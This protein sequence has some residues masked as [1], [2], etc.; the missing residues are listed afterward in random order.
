M[1]LP[2]VH[3][4]MLGFVDTSVEGKTVI[5][6]EG[7][8]SIKMAILLPT[9]KRKVISLTGNKKELTAKDVE[10]YFKAKK[11]MLIKNSTIKAVKVYMLT[12]RTYKQEREAIEDTIIKQHN[13]DPEDEK[14]DELFEKEIDKKAKEYVYSLRKIQKD[15]ILKA[16]LSSSKD[17][18]LSSRCIIFQDDKP[19][20]SGLYVV[21]SSYDNIPVEITPIKTK[22]GDFVGFY[23]ISTNKLISQ[24]HWLNLIDHY[25]RTI[26]TFV[27]KGIEEVIAISFHYDY[28][29]A[30]ALLNQEQLEF[31]KKLLSDI[32]NLTSNNNKIL[33]E[34][35]DKYI[36]KLEV[37]KTIIERTPAISPVISADIMIIN[38]AFPTKNSEKGNLVEVL[39]KQNELFVKLNYSK[40]SSE[41]QEKMLKLLNNKLE[42]FKT[43]QSGNVLASYLIQNDPIGKKKSYGFMEDNIQ[44][45]HAIFKPTKY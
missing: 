10:K 38:D 4:R 45:A 34:N 44:I 19:S 24:G 14:F 41:M 3:F 26:N 31:L 36:K 35:K 27:E 22:E 25:I 33:I 8:Y 32:R 9:G 13:I 42:Q 21:S 29:L 2:A 37:L 17:G 11:E 18:S 39:K 15:F 5:L 43:G 20:K 6:P 12:N 28:D 7:E 40:E 1:I 30:K 23:K 16:P